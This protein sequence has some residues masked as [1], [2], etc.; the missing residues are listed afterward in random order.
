MVGASQVLF[1]NE[2]NED[3]PLDEKASRFWVLGN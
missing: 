2:M 3:E 1:L